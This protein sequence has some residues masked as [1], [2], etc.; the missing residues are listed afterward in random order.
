MTGVMVREQTFRHLKPVMWLFVVLQALLFSPRLNSDGAYYYE[1]LRS[2]V[3]QNDFNFADEREFFTWEW[4]P[5]IKDYL[6][7]GWEETGY[8][9]NI[10]SFRPGNAL[11]AFFSIVP[12][13]CLDLKKSGSTGF[14]DRIW[15]DNQVFTDDVVGIGRFG[16]TVCNGSDRPAGW[17]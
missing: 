9:P 4:V 16:S 12:H 10:F 1:Y 3:L 8:P 13:N 6:P 15:S 5:V 17:I 2:W 11:D 7:G 14:D